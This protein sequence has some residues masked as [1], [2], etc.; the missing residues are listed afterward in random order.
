MERKGQA[1]MEFLMTY[2]WAILAAIIAIGVL[3][4]FGIFSPGK[5]VPDACTLSTPFG[6]LDDTVVNS[7][8]NVH[9][10]VTNGGTSTLTITSIVIGNCG[11]L[12][13]TAPGTAVTSGTNSEL[14]VTCGSALSAGSKFKGDVTITYTRPSD[15]GA[16][17]TL[18]ST[19]SLTRKVV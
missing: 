18:T 8:G 10:F 7:A 12:T 17:L 4:Y 6:C 2:G 5:F 3:A 15:T 11:T 9:L 19:G 14:T 1:A 16:T 13:P